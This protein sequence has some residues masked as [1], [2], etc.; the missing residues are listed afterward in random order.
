MASEKTLSAQPDIEPFTRKKVKAFDKRIHEI[1]FL[2]G[3]CILLVVFDH[4]AYNFY[5]FQDIAFFD[6]YWRSEFRLWFRQFILMLFCFLSG[7]SCAFSRNNWR[8]ACELVMIWLGI[9]LVTHILANTPLLEEYDV[10]DF[11]II[12]VL[13]VSTLIYCFVQNR[14]WACWLALLLIFLLF[15]MYCL[16]PLQDAYYHEINILFLWNNQPYGD[17]LSCFPYICF[18]FAGAIFSSFFYK[19][20]VSLLKHKSNLERPICWC[21]RHTIWIYILEEVITYPIFWLIYVA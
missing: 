1:D 15:A 6:W 11:N 7:I 2:R 14:S 21:G 10:I 20:R 13:A 3:I 4:L 8:R 18:F 19:N 9:A 5:A 17:Y 12:S 16:E